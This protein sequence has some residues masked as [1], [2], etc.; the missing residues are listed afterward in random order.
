M[1]LI[2]WLLSIYLMYKILVFDFLVTLGFELLLYKWFRITK[3]QTAK[4]V[5]N[6]YLVAL[7]FELLYIGYS[8]ISTDLVL[9]FTHLG[10]MGWTVG[11]LIGSGEAVEKYINNHAQKR[12]WD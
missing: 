5:K 2:M 8:G 4:A 6:I 1:Q 7:V 10:I 11:V 3:R 9:F 12:P